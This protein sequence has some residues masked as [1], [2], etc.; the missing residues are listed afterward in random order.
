MMHYKGLS[1]KETEARLK[2]FG[3]NEISSI[4][5]SNPIKILYKQLASPLIYILLAASGISLFIGEKTDAMFILVVVVVNT[6]L[7]FFQE[8]KAENTLSALKKRISKIAKVIRD[9]HTTQV[10]ASEIVPG[11]FIILD[12]GLNIPADG[13]LIESNELLINES[14]LTGES[15]PVEKNQKDRIFSGTSVIQG[16]AIAKIEVTGN[17]TEFGKIA[18]SIS[19]GS[20][21]VTPTKKR[22]I[23][24]GN[25]LSVST[26]TISVVVFLLGISRGIPVREILLISVALGVSTIP[27]GLII[28][29]TVTLALGM[30]RL[31]QKLSVVKSL[32]ATETLGNID[33]LCID[34]TG[35]ITEGKM[36]VSATDF[37][38]KI[39]ALKALSLCNNDNNFI[40]K[41]IKDYIISQ[42]GT[43]Y[44]EKAQDQRNQI[45]PFSSTYKYTGATDGKYLYAVGAPEI[46]L[47]FTS[48]P[49]KKKLQEE[50]I[51]QAN[52]GN[53]VIAVSYKKYS[54]RHIERSDFIDM[55][56]LGLI[57]INDPVRKTVVDSLQK[58]LSA[59]IS[60]KV[61]TGDL[62]E[63]SLSILEKINFAVKEDEIIS[64]FELSKAQNTPLFH[65]IVHKVRLFYRTTP[66]QKLSI[67]KSLQRQGKKVAMMGDGVNDSPALKRAEIGI[68]VNNATDVSKE[69]A[70]LI[71]LDSNFET[72]VNAIEEGR[73]IFKNLRKI[74][75]FLFSDS[76][77]ET[78]L[79]MSSLI[80]G[81]PLPITALQLLWINI[82]ED[83]LP[84]LALSFDRTEEDLMKKKH[85]IRGKSVFDKN[86]LASIVIISLITDVLYLLLFKYLIDS[87][88]NLNRAQTIIFAG[89]A[90]SSLLFLFSAKTLDSNI[91]KEKIFG[92]KVLNISVLVGIF[93]L[94]LTIYWPPLQIVLNT[95]PLDM[96]EVLV[97]IG[98]A[99]VDTILIEITKLLVRKFS[100]S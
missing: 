30:N 8:Y 85:D 12:P 88:Y 13:Y 55:K 66:E 32:H 25:I 4:D 38:D 59:G 71:L 80:L 17:S 53:R 86:V 14:V 23:S 37:T 93:L 99:I 1:S 74:F 57:F 46:I 51:E 79:I 27:E 20:D 77:S 45:F 100:R 19:S 28:A 9:G 70:D 48:D 65:K 6:S 82:I 44:Y 75:V 47:E 10:L 76:L 18:S 96:N 73:N 16:M 91:W 78:L 64:G 49:Q 2:K 61:I 21:P 43:T 90:L 72:I 34:K 87:G 63:T 33:I 39:Q 94:I 81:L 35:T 36:L 11:D 29:Y 58:V 84:S 89:I 22:L 3:K 97:I 56:F 40:D 5:K 7:G 42:R 60:V 15:F 67:V 92:N 98:V 41:S 83:G 50:I 31:L 24:I 62:M 68:A 54:K 26:V 95:V 69:S 52:L